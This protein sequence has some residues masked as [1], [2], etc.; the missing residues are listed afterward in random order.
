MLIKDYLAFEN[1]VPLYKVIYLHPYLKLN[2][3]CI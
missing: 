3:I 2:Y 1:L